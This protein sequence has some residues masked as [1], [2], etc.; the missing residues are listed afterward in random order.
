MKQY[1]RMIVVAQA[2]IIFVMAIGLYDVNKAVNEAVE[3]NETLRNHLNWMI[4]VENEMESVHKQEI[5]MLKKEYE[6]YIGYKTYAEDL[7]VII[8][9][10]KIKLAALE[11]FYERTTGYPVAEVRKAT[12]HATRYTN[13]E[14]WWE[15]DD[16]NYGMMANGQ[17]TSR[18]AVAMP[19]SI[20]FDSTVLIM[21][22]SPFGEHEEIFTVGD[23][24]GAIQEKADDWLCLDIWTPES[25]YFTM[26]IPFGRRDL[27]GYVI[28]P[29][30]N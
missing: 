16:P 11:E 9:N 12:F 7:N 6:S 5:D 10:M 3:T 1:W 8:S 15:K 27:E 21:D 20:P 28:I 2:L 23:R 4:S 17:M 22:E 19:R 18:G 24:G 14:G 29:D 26:A 30:K 13:A 25:D